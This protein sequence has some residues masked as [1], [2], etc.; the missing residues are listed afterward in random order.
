LAATLLAVHF[1]TPQWLS[2]HGEADSDKVRREARIVYGEG[3]PEVLVQEEAHQRK[4]GPTTTPR[5]SPVSAVDSRD[6]QGR[7][8]LMWAALHSQ[9]ELAKFVTN[10]GAQVNAADDQGRTALNFASEKGDVTMVRLLLNY[11]A[12]TNIRDAKG[13]SPLMRAAENG[14]TPVIEMLL[15]HGAEVGGVSHQ[16]KTALGLAAEQA[17]RFRRTADVLKK[18]GGK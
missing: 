17:D 2:F 14:H 15:R 9:V 12:D 8:V 5:R 6:P 7:T 16:G 1:W 10:S 11:R 18:H 13:Y 3:G 4:V